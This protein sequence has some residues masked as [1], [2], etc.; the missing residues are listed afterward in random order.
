MI[1]RSGSALAVTDDSVKQFLNIVP[2][3]LTGPES[4]TLIGQL[5]AIDGESLDEVMRRLGGAVKAMR[6][7]RKPGA[8]GGT[9]LDGG[10]TTPTKPK[11]P[12]PTAAGAAQAGKPGADKAA[13]DHYRQ[14]ALKLITAYG[15]WSSLEP[16]KLRVLGYEP[17]W[18]LAKKGAN[19][20]VWAAV[21]LSGPPERHG[22]I[23]LHVKLTDNNGTLANV[24]VDSVLPLVLDDGSELDYVNN[25]EKRT[26]SDAK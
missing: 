22:A 8:G 21:R 24:V 13:A 5:Q 17:D 4:A 25:G 14:S 23:F 19:I 2:A 15:G 9:K 6:E 16:G 12:R 1:G 20:A 26:L 11:K 7:K 10:S 18:H 3:D